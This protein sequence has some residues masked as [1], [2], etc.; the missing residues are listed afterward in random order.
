MTAKRFFKCAKVK[1]AR[2]ALRF[3]V[4]L[5]LLAGLSLKLITDGINNGIDFIAP[6]R[7]YAFFL[8]GTVI[9]LSAALYLEDR[10][11]GWKLHGSVAAAALLWGAYCVSLPSQISPAYFLDTGWIDFFAFII[12]I[13]PNTYIFPVNFFRYSFLE[14]LMVAAGAALLMFIPFLTKGKDGEFINFFSTVCRHAALAYIISLPLKIPLAFIIYVGLPSSCSS[15][16]L[17][18]GTVLC[19]VLLPALWVMA[20]IPDRCAKHKSRPA[21]NRFPKAIGLFLRP[22]VA[23]YTIILCIGYISYGYMLIIGKLQWHEGPEN[24]AVT[25]GV[26]AALGLLAIMFLYPLRLRGEMTCGN[27]EFAEDFE[28]EYDE[29]SDDFILRPPYRKSL[30]AARHSRW[31]CIAILPLL[32]LMLIAIMIRINEYG[33]TIMRGYFLLVCLWFGAV[34]AYLLRTD[35]RGVKWIPVSLGALLIVSSAGPWSVSNVTKHILTSNIT[36]YMDNKALLL[37]HDSPRDMLYYA[38]GNNT[39]DLHHAQYRVNPLN[40]I[41]DKRNEA[42]VNDKIDYLRGAYTWENN[43]IDILRNEEYETSDSYAAGD[44]I[45]KTGGNQKSVIITGYTGS[46]TVLS[47]PSKLD[48]KT[49]VKIGTG[50]FAGKGLVRV[51]IPRGVTVIGARAFMQNRIA[52]VIIPSG[53]TAIG[54]EAF[55]DNNLTAVAIPGSAAVIDERAFAYNELTGVTLR[56]GTKVIGPEAFAG[57]LLTTV[58]I[59]N[60]VK[61]IVPNAFDGK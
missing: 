38:L 48:G 25:V 53:I 32:L 19:G 41:T 7:L 8:G 29:K 50:A 47:I 34:F 45:V 52:D 35:S 27:D 17:V 22:L 20:F 54:A 42:E 40:Y 30:A 58:K 44:F 9:C 13:D 18:A 23:L 39:T 6:D 43:G 55:L 3:P 26:L 15:P 12:L 5:L 49:V 11:R 1:T 37:D 57:N 46:D 2:M 36:R 4:S 33:I 51:A 56:G 16:G 10:L 59:P 14:P 21:R 28:T 24:L 60:S 61:L 31:F